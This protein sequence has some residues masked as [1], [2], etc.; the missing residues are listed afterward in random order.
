M[1]C[2]LAVLAM[3]YKSSEPWLSDLFRFVKQ[4]RKQAYGGD[5]PRHDLD[6]DLHTKSHHQSSKHSNVL[7]FSLAIQYFTPSPHGH[8]KGRDLPEAEES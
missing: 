7:L 2:L 1:A 5:G 8:L 4:P 6:Y 3:A